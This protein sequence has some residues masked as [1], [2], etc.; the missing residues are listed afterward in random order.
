MPIRGTKMPFVVD[1]VYYVSHTRPNAFRTIKAAMDHLY[2]FGLSQEP[3]TIQID[4]GTYEGPIVADNC[5]SLFVSGLGEKTIITSGNDC[6]LKSYNNSVLDVKDLTFR[7]DGPS[8]KGFE[9]YA[10][11]RYE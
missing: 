2:T 1:R 8:F 6:C 5:A 10:K 11:G 9:A 3:A 7:V 4:E